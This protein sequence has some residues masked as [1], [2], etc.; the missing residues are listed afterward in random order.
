MTKRI[1]D[2]DYLVISARV[3]AMEPTLLTTERME[4][5]LAARTDG[6]AQKLLREYGY[7]ELDAADPAAMDAAL[8]RVRAEVL[9]DL[10]VGM[11]DLRIFDCFRLKYDYHN[12]KVILKSRAMKIDPARMLTDL[13]R[14]SVENLRA[15]MEQETLDNLPGLM[16]EAVPEAKAVLDSTRD[17]QLCDIVL[18]RWM[19]RDMTEEAENV[20]SPFLAGFVCRQIDAANLRALVRALRIGK[21]AAFLKEVFADGGEIKV[22][23]LLSMSERSGDGLADLYAGTGLAAA[24]E[25]GEEALRGGALTAFET[26]C[27]NAV[28]RY[29]EE[30]RMI[31]FGDAPVLAYLAAKET[32]LINLRI[33]MLGRAAGLP[34]DVIRSRLR[35]VCV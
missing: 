20:G 6:E 10:E 5:L 14:I 25:A 9:R 7:P 24:A 2:T 30:A 3:R 1:K 13:G 11:P 29:L 33:L 32:E 16:G 8:R 21:G 26:E 4:R 15:A 27:D 19:M 17:P 31:P 34:P 12:A 18:D 35:T 23:Q 28:S 22:E